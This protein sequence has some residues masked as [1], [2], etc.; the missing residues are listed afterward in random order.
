MPQSDYSQSQYE[1]DFLT[2]ER[3]EKALNHAL[4]IRKFE[5][6]LYWKRATY[7]WTFI[8]AI[9]AGFI[10]IN[11]SETVNKQDLSVVL[12]CLGV[13]FS[14]AWVCVNRGS[15]QWQENWEKHVDM[16]EDNVTG[17][18]YKVVL[19][20]RKPSGVKDNLIHLATGPSPIS[21]SKVNQLISLYVTVLWIALLI[22]SLPEFN[23]ETPFHKFYTLM[24]VLTIV[25]C[26]SFV[27]LARTYNGGF[28]HGATIR[29]TEIKNS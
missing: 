28:W 16:L 19:K 2:E 15:K 4:D 6:E 23:L 3:N 24:V 12:S 9:F 29:T 25:F 10:A 7:F 8:G 17:P 13:V 26:W 27:A 5:I 14:F 20:R 18:L 21:V 11:A 22:Y 1:A